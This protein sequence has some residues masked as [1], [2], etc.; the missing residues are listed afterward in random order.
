MKKMKSVTFAQT[1]NYNKKVSGRIREGSR[2]GLVL[3]NKKIGSK[4]R[5]K[6]C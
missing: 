5:N 6:K 4:K 3:Y 2:T 1:R